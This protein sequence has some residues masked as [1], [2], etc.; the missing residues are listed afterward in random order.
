[1]ALE[2]AKT[3]VYSRLSRTPALLPLRVPTVKK[4]L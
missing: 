2:P 3:T 1:V 4:R